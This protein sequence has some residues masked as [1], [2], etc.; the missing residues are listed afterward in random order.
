MKE[1]NP[2]RGGEAAAED[3]KGKSHEKIQ[4]AAA[5]LLRTDGIGGASVRRVMAAAG[6]TGGGFYAHFPSKATLTQEAFSC[7]AREKR[8]VL[9]ATLGDARGPSYIDRFLRAYLTR[10][11][12]DDLQT[13]C[14]YAALLSELPR[15]SRAVRSRVRE[16]FSRGVKAFAERLEGREP[17]EA[18]EKAILALCLA[19]GALAMSRT[20]ADFPEGDEV[21]DLAAAGAKYFKGV[22]SRS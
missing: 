10:D 3:R 20:L 15:S 13:G 6:M 21:L 18:R 7:A 22:K 8:R 4:G 14:P 12:R 9:S 2:R 11:H 5:R 19:F 16:E 17:S 1:R